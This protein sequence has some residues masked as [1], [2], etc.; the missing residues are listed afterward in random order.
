[1]TRALIPWLAVWSMLG[2]PAAP[3]LAGA[4]TPAGQE[5]P[6]RLAR[7]VPRTQ[8]SRLQVPT[9]DMPNL[10]GMTPQAAQGH[11]V[12]VKLRLAL[13]TEPIESTLHRP[14]TIARQSV[15]A[16]QPVRGGARV[17]V[18][19]VAGGVEVPAVEGLTLDAA[20]ERLA[21]LGFRANVTTTSTRATIGDI[22]GF[23][24]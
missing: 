3:W 16:G 1:M 4:A 23:P 19:V 14:G 6:S 17:I 12:V 22:R 18:Y 10:V 2:S 24:S 15:Q 21:R 20:R 11:P 9:A 7:Q 8:A 5:P 13:V